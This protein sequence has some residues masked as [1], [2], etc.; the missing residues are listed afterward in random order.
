MDIG[1]RAMQEQ[2]PRKP[3][4]ILPNMC[5]C[6]AGATVLQKFEILQL[7]RRQAVRHQVLILACVGS[8]KL[9]GTILNISD[10]CWWPEGRR[11]G[12]PE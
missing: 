3:G 11:A 5:L 1:G 2:L 6:L 8:T 9:S 7:G 4:V 10:F 12:S